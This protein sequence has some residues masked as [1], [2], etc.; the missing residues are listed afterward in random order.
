MFKFIIFVF[1]LSSLELFITK[2]YTIK[3]AKKYD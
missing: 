1:V 3:F 2:Y